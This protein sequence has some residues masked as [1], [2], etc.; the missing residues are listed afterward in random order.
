[1]QVTCDRV[2]GMG[3]H[4]VSAA[5]TTSGSRSCS[6]SR[7]AASSACRGP[8]VQHDPSSLGP[9]RCMCAPDPDDRLVPP[10]TGQLHEVVSPA[11]GS[12]G[13]APAD[14]L[15]D[16]DE[17][18]R[19]GPKRWPQVGQRRRAAAQRSGHPARA[20]DVRRCRLEARGSRRWRWRD[21][22]HGVELQRGP[23]RLVPAQQVVVDL[24]D[25]QAARPGAA[26]RCPAAGRRRRG[27]AP[28]R[29]ARAC[30]EIWAEAGPRAAP[31]RR[32][33]SI[34]CRPGCRPWP[35]RPRS[36]GRGR[37]WRGGPRCCS[38]RTGSR[39]CRSSGSRAG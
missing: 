9:V 27:P 22:G 12:V 21:G 19:P 10:W 2:A 25:D 29:S 3:D 15:D 20:R 31:S 32:S 37:G 33:T 18:H 7:S 35:R 38:G 6:W 16:V 8:G 28:T 36:G 24:H 1:M 11:G 23:H 14:A 39:R 13:I 4:R 5:C 34:P 26:R 30:L 17:A